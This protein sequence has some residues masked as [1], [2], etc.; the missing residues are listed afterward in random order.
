MNPTIRVRY[1]RTVC[2][3][4]GCHRSAFMDEDRCIDHQRMPGGA[5]FAAWFLFCAFVALALLAGAGWA[6]FELVMWVTQK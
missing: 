6:V 3:K 1:R 5:L 2:T 4:P